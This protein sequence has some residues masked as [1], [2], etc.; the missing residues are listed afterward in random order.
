M[1]KTILSLLLSTVVGMT[2]SQDEMRTLFKKDTAAKLD[3]YGGYGAPFA[4]FTQLQGADA[5][6][7]G[8][9]GGVTKN[10]HFTFGGV[11]TAIIGTKNFKYTEI[12]KNVFGADST[13]DRSTNLSMGYGGLF[14]EYTFDHASPVHISIPVNFQVGGVS[15]ISSNKNFDKTKTDTKE[16]TQVTSSSIFVVE[17]GLSFNFNFYKFFVP[18]VN[19]GY[20][21]VAGS[22]AVHAK[23]LS[24]VYGSI[25]LKFGK[26]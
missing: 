18:S 5:I 9:K 21:F 24:G 12:Q 23:Q 6:I 20:R 4:G 2:Y 8:G 26:F 3:S 13:I 19:I 10:H 7:V 16:Y 14:I 11:G 15:A 1:K 17:P 22:K 25:I